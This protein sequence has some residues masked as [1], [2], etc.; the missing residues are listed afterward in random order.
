MQF[1]NRKIICCTCSA[2]SEEHIMQVSI[3]LKDEIVKRLN[4][5]AESTG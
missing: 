5:L 4:N 2:K 1:C 3:R